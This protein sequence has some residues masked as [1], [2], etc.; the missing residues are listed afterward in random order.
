[1][2][3]EQIEAR[4]E[5]IAAEIYRLEHM[6]STHEIREEIDDLYIELEAL[7]SYRVYRP[8]RHKRS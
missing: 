8:P 7:D 2:K 6:L 3:R 4:A 1:M 5:Q